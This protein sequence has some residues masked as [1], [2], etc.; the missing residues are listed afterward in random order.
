ME[1]FPPMPDGGEG[2]RRWIGPPLARCDSTFFFL[3]GPVI[4]N[5]PFGILGFNFHHILFFFFVF[6]GKGDNKSC[7]QSFPSLKSF[8]SWKE[9]WSN[10]NQFFQTNLIRM[11]VRRRRR[12]SDME[13]FQRR[14]RV[15]LTLQAT[16]K[17][18]TT[19][20]DD[21]PIIYRV[22]TIPGG[23][24][25]CPST[26]SHQ[27]RSSEHH[28]LKSAGWEMLVPRRVSIDYSGSSNRW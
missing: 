27:T 20:D 4:G 11:L 21:Y 26:V 7:I 25:F 18:T 24:P 16:R 12:A 8:F 3:K 9:K 17:P 28:R 2:K 10:R 14:A 23:A 19:K 22:L 6:F 1:A 5:L 15:L 13:R